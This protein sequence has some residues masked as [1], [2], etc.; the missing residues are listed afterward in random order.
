MLSHVT[1]DK[2]LYVLFL[3]PAPSDK[4]IY[5]LSQGLLCPFFHAPAASTKINQIL[6]A[7]TCLHV[8]FSLDTTRSVFFF[9]ALVAY[10]T[11]NIL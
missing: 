1:Y 9:R 3:Y 10:V 8:L 2:V 5:K 11:I 6:D 4:A 7:F